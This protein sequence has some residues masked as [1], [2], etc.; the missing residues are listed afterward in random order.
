M[1]DNRIG[2]TRSR[3]RRVD[4]GARGVRK[5]PTCRAVVAARAA[6]NRSERADI[7]GARLV[8]L[9]RGALV[10]GSFYKISAIT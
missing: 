3:R 9:Q 2:G 8:Q 5:G 6:V 7:I 1:K 10:N 4:G